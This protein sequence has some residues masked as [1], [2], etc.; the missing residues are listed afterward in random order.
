MVYIYQHIFFYINVGIAY[1]A[2]LNIEQII[3][4]QKFKILIISVCAKAHAKGC[5]F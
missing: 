2:T 4:M 3:I 5:L 1:H